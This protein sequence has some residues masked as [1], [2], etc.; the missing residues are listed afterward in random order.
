VTGSKG[1]IRDGRRRMDRRPAVPGVAEILGGGESLEA[2]AKVPSGSA[3]RHERIATSARAAFCNAAP[4]L[5]SRCVYWP[6]PVF[7]HQ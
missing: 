2:K 1:S 4:T 6:A 5:W 3:P 7:L